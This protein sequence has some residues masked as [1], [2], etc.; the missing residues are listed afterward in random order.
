MLPN[1]ILVNSETGE[2]VDTI[3]D[4]HFLPRAGE[5]IQSQ[6][7]THTIHSV[8][9]ELDNY[10]VMTRNVRLLVETN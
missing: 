6:Y 10:G 8:V 4:A 7:G 5:S 1:L 2:Q 9:Y 3:D